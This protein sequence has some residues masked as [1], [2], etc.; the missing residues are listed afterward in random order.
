MSKAVI[1]K[2]KQKQTTPPQ[3]TTL[4]AYFRMAYANDRDY[5]EPDLLKDSSDQLIQNSN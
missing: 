4:T 2:A 3:T 1:Q 5:D